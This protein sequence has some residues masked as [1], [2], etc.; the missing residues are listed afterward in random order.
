MNLKFFL[1]LL[2][3]IPFLLRVSSLYSQ[4][5]IEVLYHYNY[6]DNNS[7]TINHHIENWDRPKLSKLIFNDSISFFRSYDKNIYKEFEHLYTPVSHHYKY[8][9]KVV[10]SNLYQVKYVSNKKQVTI[11]IDTIAKPVWVIDS[12][13]KY[14]L[15]YRCR[16]A[17]TIKPS[18]DTLFIFFAVDIKLPFGPF[19]YF[20]AP[21]LIVEVFD[22]ETNFYIIAKRIKKVNYE[23]RLPDDKN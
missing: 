15:N 9:M 21:G 8:Y 18:K 10:D 22:T 12:T 1:H 11:K 3:S 17:F 16:E 19:E 4:N 5:T 6:Y 23:M 13:D 14:F 20:G 2:F 7:F